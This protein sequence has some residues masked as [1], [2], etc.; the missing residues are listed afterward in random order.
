MSSEFVARARNFPKQIFPKNCYN[1][2]TFTPGSIFPKT[3]HNFGTFTPGPIFPKTCHNFGTFTPS[4]DFQKKTATF[5]GLFPNTNFG[6]FRFAFPLFWIYRM[7]LSLF[8]IHMGLLSLGRSFSCVWH[9]VFWMRRAHGVSRAQ[10]FPKNL[11]QFWDFHEYK[12]SLYFLL[13]GGRTF[14][15][16]L[17][18]LVCVS[19]F[20]NL[21]HAS[22]AR[23]HYEIWNMHIRFWRV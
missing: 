9:R 8:W 12:L 22:T 15:T 2:G 4:L 17:E 23:I 3:C 11:P 13:R 1:F 10:F 7:Y 19:F 21:P 5:L 16:F 20:L 18:I 6:N 14:T